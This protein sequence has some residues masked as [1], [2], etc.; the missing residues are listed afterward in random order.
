MQDNI[1]NVIKV[2]YEK[3]FVEAEFGSECRHALLVGI[4]AEHVFCRI[5]GREIDHAEYD[6]RYTEQH[7]YHHQDSLHYISK[8]S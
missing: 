2:L 5:A 7:R 1:F 4:H 3:R 8:H 6:E